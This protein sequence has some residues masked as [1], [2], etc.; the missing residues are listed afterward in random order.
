MSI[1][2]ELERIQGLRNELRI[3][4]TG[5]NLVDGDA[6]LETCVEALQTV[7]TFGHTLTTL[8]YPDEYIQLPA[9]YYP[10]G[11]EV[12]LQMSDQQNIT[13][14]NIKKGVTILGV[15]GSF[16]SD[17]TAADTDILSGQ[18]AYVNG[19]KITGTIKKQAGIVTPTKSAQMIYPD[20]GSL[21]NA[22][23]VNAIPSTYFDISGTNA[24][25]SDV[26][27][28]A[29]FVDMYGNLT[30]GSIPV[31]SPVQTVLDAEEVSYSIPEGY[32]TLG[33]TV[34]IVAEEKTVVPTKADRTYRPADGKVFSSFTV[35][36][37]GDDYQDVSATTLT[38]QYAIAGSKFVA[39]D[40]TV[41]WGTM[42][43]KGKV[44]A[45]IDGLDTL[46]Y[47]IPQGYH[48]GNGTVSLTG[49]I[50][51]ALASI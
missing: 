50:E 21:F 46:S 17:A 27:K 35:E 34:S 8:T 2:T 9:G 45:T 23:A 29:Q 11:C 26:L 48:N 4:L 42:P 14:S 19:N 22:V 24:V 7:D 38:A 31:I 43:N 30:E 1:Q 25:S 10:T 40:G 5:M 39:K 47:T 12:A 44:T 32:H 15:E 28:G 49:D 51:A 37:I 3:H 6:D 16:T 18:T 36:A 33:G 20:A 13:E 41:V